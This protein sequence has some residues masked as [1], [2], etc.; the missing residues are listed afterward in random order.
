VEITSLGDGIAYEIGR[1]VTRIRTA[2]G[3]SIDV[4]GNSLCTFRRESDG[5]WRA[6]VDIFNV[7]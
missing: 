3:S 1:S 6:D 5:V 4:R 7:A 2:D